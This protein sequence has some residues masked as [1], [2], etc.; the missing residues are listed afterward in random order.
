VI[1]FEEIIYFTKQRHP[2]RQ[3]GGLARLSFHP[4]VSAVGLFFIPKLNLVN[5]GG[6][7]A[8]I[9]VDD[10]LLLWIALYLI[11]NQI[12]KMDFKVTY[13]TASCLAV[14]G[15]F[16]ISNV[17]NLHHSSLFYAL[18]I[19]EY[20]IFLWVGKSFAER[21]N[22]QKTL[23]WLIFINCTVIFLQ[24][25]GIIG[26]FRWE[27]YLSKIS[28]PSG[29]ANHQAEM[30]AW[31][32][33]M[34]AALVFGGRV[35]FWRWNLLV[36]ISI[37]L[38]GS[39]I[40]LAAHCILTLIYVY[41]GS[42]H[43]GLILLRVAVVAGLLSSTI[44]FIPNRV[45]ERSGSV[46]SLDN[47]SMFKNYYDKLPVEAEFADFSD[48][49]DP[50]NSPDSVDPS[51]WMRVVKWSQ[52]IKLYLNA[53]L[54]TKAFGIGPGTLG[55]ALD[56]G[57]LR[58]IVES[59]VVGVFFFVFMFRKIAALSTA[60]SMAVLALSI[61]ML[62]IDSHLSYKVMAFLFFLAGYTYKRNIMGQ[63]G[64]SISLSEI[65]GTHNNLYASP[66]LGKTLSTS[67]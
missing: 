4:V 12:Q 2:A 56:G 66:L 51:W 59:G 57:W 63:P 1:P 7:T 61:N 14:A 8:G 38:T 15:S 5:I 45:S 44:A 19:L 50:V 46:L 10:L 67:Q 31:L 23:K 65:E 37:F 21:G 26:A 62:M 55:P 25:A 16:F 33:L 47:L 36:L 41:R 32:N 54:I 34:F 49:R 35:K 60:C 17:I 6:E 3:G 64:I 24:A 53:S 13:L 9:R 28:F 43:K 20:L 52:V 30:G 40:S 39:R 11:V 22:L 58:L 27:G 18:R 48:D 42:K 29:L